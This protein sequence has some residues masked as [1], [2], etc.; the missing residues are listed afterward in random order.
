MHIAV[1]LI[2]DNIIIAKYI[3]SESETFGSINASSKK[4]VTLAVS[5]QTDSSIIINIG[6]AYSET[7]SLNLPTN[8]NIISG[9]Y[10]KFNLTLMA[11]N[12][13]ISGGN[14]LSNILPNSSFNVCKAV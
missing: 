7:N 5:N 9:E 13:S 14:T 6:V 2:N 4:K 12:G 10:G 1:L 8:R 11:R 3:D